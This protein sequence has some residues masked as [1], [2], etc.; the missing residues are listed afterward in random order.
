MNC[1]RI[2]FLILAAGIICSCNSQKDGVVDPLVGIIHAT[3]DSLFR[4][5]INDPDKYQF[6][7]RYTQVDRNK[8]NQPILTSHE[9]NVD[10]NRYFYP[11]STV[12]MPVAFLALQR[13]NELQLENSDIDKFSRLEYGAEAPPQETMTI[14]SSSPTGYPQVAHFIEQVFSVSDNEAYNRLYEFLGQDYI[15]EQLKEKGVFRN[16]RIRTRVGISGFDTEANKYTNPIRILNE[17]AEEVYSQ[18]EYYALYDHYSDVSDMHRGKGYYD[19]DLD[20]VILEPF[21]MSKK[22]FITLRDLEASLSRVMIPEYYEPKERYNLTAEDYKFLYEIMPQYPLDFSYHQDH[23]EDYYNTYVK[24]FWDGNDKS[25]IPEHIKIYNKVGWAYGTL[26]DCSYIID[27]KNGI[28]F[29]LTATI[30]V[31]ENQIYNDGEYQ[32]D[33]IGLPFFAALGEAVY[34]HELNRKRSNT[35]DLSQF[36]N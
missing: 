1:F 20:T 15:N 18:D 25:P 8:E 34:Q 29:F 21:D 9:Y 31:N 10:P 5:V 6:Q 12:K 22:N 30:L 13:I 2:L 17:D 3:D 27:I 4:E 32:Y 16:S 33:E 19:S 36:I 26:T 24:F 35:P 28:E 11:A 7:I 14:D 23:A